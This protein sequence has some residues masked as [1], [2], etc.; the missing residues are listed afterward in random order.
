METSDYKI[1]RSQLNLDLRSKSYHNFMFVD[2]E[3]LQINLGLKQHT[4][5]TIL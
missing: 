1:A 2:S 3:V 5:T 4:H